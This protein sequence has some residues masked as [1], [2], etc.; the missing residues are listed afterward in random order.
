MCESRLNFI[1]LHFSVP[2]VQLG[3]V[4]LTTLS[5]ISKH[6][7]NGKGRGVGM[8]IRK[9]NNKGKGEIYQGHISWKGAYHKK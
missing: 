3:E 1:A 8:V 7:M 9:T 6:I 5:A 2:R 4:I